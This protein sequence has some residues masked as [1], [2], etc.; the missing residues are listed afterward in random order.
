MATIVTEPS[1][2]IINQ[3]ATLYYTNISPIPLP[4]TSYVLKIGSN[5]VSD[6]YTGTAPILNTVSTNVVNNSGSTNSSSV[7]Y[8]GNIYTS[9]IKSNITGNGYIQKTDASGVSSI[10]LQFNNGK[11][12]N[13]P[14]TNYVPSNYNSPQ[15]PTGLVL[16]TAGNLY[17]LV[18]GDNNI[19]KISNLSN[20]YGYTQFNRSDASGASV[21]SAPFDMTIDPNTN[22]MYVTATNPPFYIEKIDTSGTTSAL[23][24][25]TAG[26]VSYGICCDLSSNLYIGYAN[27]TIGKYDLKVNTFTSNFI[28]LPSGAGTIYGLTY[29]RYANSLIAVCGDTGNV[30]GIPLSVL[31]YTPLIIPNSGIL[32]SFTNRG[33]D[34]IYGATASNIISYT[35]NTTFTF[36]N[37]LLPNTTNT[38]TIYNQSASSSGTSFNVN[39]VTTPSNNPTTKFLF[40]GLDLSNIFQPL[41]LG[42]KSNITTNYTVTGYGDLNNIFAA[43]NDLGYNTGYTTLVN[44]VNTD[45]SQIFAKFN[46]VYVIPDPSLNLDSQYYLSGNTWLNYGAG[47]STFNATLNNSPTFYSSGLQ[48]YFTLNG[49]NQSFMITRPNQTNF[50]WNVW[51]KTTTTGGTKGYWWQGLQIIGGDTNQVTTGDFGL[52]IAQGYLQFGIGANGYPD[53]TV[54]TKS[55][56]NDNNWHMVT[57]TR[58]STTG[59]ISIFVDGSL[60]NTLPTQLTQAINGVPQVYFG[61]DYWTAQNFFPGN[62][63]IIQYYSQVLSS[64]TISVLYNSLSPRY[65]NPV[66]YSNSNGTETQQT[67]Y[68]KVLYNWTAPISGYFTKFQITA[69]G[70]TNNSNLINIILNRNGNSIINGQ[71]YTFPTYQTQN[72]TTPTGTYLD[73]GDQIYIDYSTMENGR[74]FQCLVRSDG[75][76]VISIY[77]QPN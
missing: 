12:P 35:F 36:T 54:T 20:P 76:P 32:G 21:I 68:N 31:T 4:N 72:I 3:P 8:N 42:S 53:Y 40:G 26:V 52:S 25:Y 65:L 71:W 1:P 9:M 27:S 30:Y 41:S 33:Y 59:D 73:A 2:P 45:L 58:N 7:Y 49:T 62:I 24:N 69:T 39:A 67:V 56:Y 29:A 60:N 6:T 57:A 15:Y 37:L 18:Y 22:F 64:G 11:D 19:Y 75:V 17:F 23:P 13:Y 44:G 63:A 48:S 16:D 70:A 34:T 77:I 50:T 10:Y 47:G 14:T 46:N 55:T 74:Y 51:F 43:G 61:R 66:V 5:S 28:T 38:L